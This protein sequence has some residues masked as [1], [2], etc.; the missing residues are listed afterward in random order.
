MDDGVVEVG[1]GVDNG[2]IAAG[3]NILDV[4]DTGWYFGVRREWED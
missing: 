1:E 3:A 4:L 2:E